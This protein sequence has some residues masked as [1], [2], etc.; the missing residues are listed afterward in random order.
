MLT[1]Y[2]E[3]QLNLSPDFGGKGTSAIWSQSPGHAGKAI[4]FIHG[5]G[6]N[7]LKTWSE[8]NKLLPLEPKAA[9]YDL[10]FYGYDGLYSTI[11]SRACLQ[12]LL[13]LVYCIV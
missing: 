9:D 12:T 10:I 1:H 2:P 7:A 3:R 6:G 8:F 4:V 5:Y 13:Q 11:N